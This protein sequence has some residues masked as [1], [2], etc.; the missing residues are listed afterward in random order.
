M[1]KISQTL[2]TQA[3]VLY[4]YI[5]ASADICYKE[6]K[7]IVA[8]FHVYQNAPT[9]TFLLNVYGHLC[10]FGL[11]LV[12]L[13]TSEGGKTRLG[14]Q[15]HMEGDESGLIFRPKPVSLRTRV[16]VP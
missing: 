1:S 15:F 14:R 7:D 13:G 5:R 2:C 16:R 10:G 11:V 8:L 4:L 3:N 9:N 12:S 6:D